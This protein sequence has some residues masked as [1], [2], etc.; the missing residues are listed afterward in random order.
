MDFYQHLQ[1]IKMEISKT[2]KK[3]D[4]KNNNNNNPQTNQPTKNPHQTE[5]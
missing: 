3:R 4:W 1:T 5:D 2:S